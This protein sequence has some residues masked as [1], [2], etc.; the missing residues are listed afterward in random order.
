MAKLDRT[1]E[2]F[3]KLVPLLRSDGFMLIVLQDNPD[4]DAVAAAAALRVV[5]HHYGNLQCS[6]AHG[7]TVGR[8]ENRAL[9][10]YLGLNLRALPQLDLEAFDLVAMVDAQPGAGNQSLPTSRLPDIVIDHHPIRKDTRSCRYTDIRSKY[11]STSTILWE[12][13]VRAGMSPEMPLATALLYGIRSDTQD[14]GREATAADITAVERLYPLINKRMLSQIMRGRLTHSWFQ[15]LTNAL[16]RALIFEDAIIASLG[17]VDNPDMMGEAADLFLRHE[18]VRWTL[19]YG[20][21]KD[22]ILLSIRSGGD[23]RRAEE[24]A[25]K[26][27]SR[28]GTSG[29]HATMAGAQIPLKQDS[30]EYIRKM[31]NRISDRFLKAIGRPGAEGSPLVD[32]V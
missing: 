5:A 20:L 27:A 26:I 14:L 11:G 4:P 1:S 13:L 21:Y 10:E 8:A 18:R 23:T 25:H 12:Y 7:G 17:R 24:I 29:G 22:K 3:A 30:Q 15:M 9:I 6:L 2:R 31:E 16:Q 28:I 19:S 32:P